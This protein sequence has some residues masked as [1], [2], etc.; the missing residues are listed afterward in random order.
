MIRTNA[1]LRETLFKE[2]D[3]V[4]A[5]RVSPQHA[6]AVAAVAKQILVS[7]RLDMD[8]R[9]LH[10]ATQD[11]VLANLPDLQLTYDSAA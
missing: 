2:L 6:R 9:A 3:D 4:M 5:S 1:G 10:G 8:N 7:A 11:G